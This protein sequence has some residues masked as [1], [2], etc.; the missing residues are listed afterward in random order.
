MFVAAIL[1]RPM[2]KA[3]VKPTATKKNYDG[4]E[5]ETCRS[6]KHADGHNDM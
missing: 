5:S 2:N 4:P 6:H 3:T 1:A